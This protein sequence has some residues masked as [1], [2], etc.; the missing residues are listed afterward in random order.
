MRPAPETPVCLGCKVGVAKRLL[1]IPTHGVIPAQ[2]GIQ[3]RDAQHASGVRV[4]FSMDS[5]LRRNDAEIV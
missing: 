1:C 4:A 3:V 2:D 5:G